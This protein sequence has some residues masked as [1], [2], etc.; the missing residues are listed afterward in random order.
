MLTPPGD[1]ADGDRKMNRLA[2]VL[3]IFLL[4]AGGYLFGQIEWLERELMDLRARLM[5]HPAS[6]DL[7]LVQI[8]EPSLREFSVW[9]WPRHLH[10]EVL[11]R[12]V[13]A[14]ARQVAFDIDFSST[15][16]PQDDRV[17]AQ[18]LAEAARTVDIILPVFRQPVVQ[19]DG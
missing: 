8:D 11:K 13:D 3:L 6:T 18:A 4:V 7:V 15:S 14:G 12:L 2:R 9:P 16:S 1:S 17:L 10:A 19:P 5:H